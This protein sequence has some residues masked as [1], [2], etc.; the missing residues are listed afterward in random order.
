MINKFPH[1]LMQCLA[2]ITQHHGLQITPEQL[3]KPYALTEA[4]PAVEL[5]MQI[6][7]NNGLNAALQKLS[8]EALVELHSVFPAIV[9]LNNGNGVIIVGV[10][11]EGDGKVAILDP[12]VNFPVAQMLNRDQ[13]CSQ[14]GGEVLVFQLANQ[15]GNIMIHREIIGNYEDL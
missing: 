9:R 13:F 6:A 10:F 2:A 4:E 1:T 3:V 15:A 11:V 12:L 8:W 14:W 5:L 7:V